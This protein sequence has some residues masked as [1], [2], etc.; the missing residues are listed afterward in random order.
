MPGS[1]AFSPEQRRRALREYMK[2]RG[3]KVYP[4][5]QEAGISEGTL[6]N[7]LKGD[8][9]SMSD[10]S[11]ALLAR[12]DGTT[13][14]VLRGELPDAPAAA[15]VPVRSFVGAGDEI[16]PITGDAPIDYVPAP[17]GM[18]EAEATEVRGRSMLPL[19]HD[20]DL[21]FHRRVDRDPSRFRDQV[22]VVQVR[23][24]KRFVKLIQPGR[25][26]GRFDLISFNPAF[27]PIENQPIEWVGPIEWV[28]KRRQV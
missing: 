20:G 2:R 9:D 28:R 11:Y 13:V 15:E 7:F 4:W 8:S 1:K 27:A 14:A 10:R 22:V 25:Q 12:A 24:G 19:Y 21:L 17:P 23:N 16:F 26:R 5:T 6:R 18:E 3:L